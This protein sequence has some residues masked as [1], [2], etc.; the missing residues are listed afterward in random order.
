M[1][2]P[3]KADQSLHDI[4]KLCTSNGFT[5]HE[6]GSRKLRKSAKKSRGLSKRRSGKGG[7][8]GKG[9]KKGMLRKTSRLAY[10]K[11]HGEGGKRRRCPKYCR[12]KTLRCKTYG[13][14]RY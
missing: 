13:L 3:G 6:G 2:T 4:E 9:T 11:R 7:T 10:S 8:K 12:R 1:S 5:K 14:R